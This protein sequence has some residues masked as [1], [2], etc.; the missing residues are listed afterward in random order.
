[1][2]AALRTGYEVITGKEVPF[3]KLDIKP[4]RGMEGIKE[5]GIPLPK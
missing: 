2:E 4:V 1:M 3:A 5:A